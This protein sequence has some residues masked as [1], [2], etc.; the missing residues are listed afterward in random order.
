MVG[1]FPPTLTRNSQ[2]QMHP[3]RKVVEA[4]GNPGIKSSQAAQPLRFRSCGTIPRLK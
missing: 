1:V 4:R 2:R 3:D